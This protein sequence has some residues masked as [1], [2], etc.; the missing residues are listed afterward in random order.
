M[1]VERRRNRGTCGATTCAIHQNVDQVGGEAS[2]EAFI[3]LCVV[4]E[5]GGTSDGVKAILEAEL[6]PYMVPQRIVELDRMP[7]LPNG[8][9]DRN[10]LYASIEQVRRTDILPPETAAQKLV[11]KIWTELTSTRDIGLYDNFFDV[12]GHSLSAIQSI[13]MIEQAT[14]IRLTPKVIVTSTLK[15][16][17]AVLGPL[18]DEAG[19]GQPRKLLQRVASALR[20]LG[21]RA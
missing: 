16:V 9:L 3:A 20:A 2:T 13:L 7:L 8:K 6:P 19:R 18:D 4:A 21:G 17:A 15:E 5:P 12:G 10:A 11:A 1:R 14:G